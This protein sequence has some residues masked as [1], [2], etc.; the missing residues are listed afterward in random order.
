MRASDT[1]PGS[2]AEVRTSRHLTIR[3]SLPAPPQAGG[4]N[5]KRKLAP[6][7]PAELHPEA[8]QPGRLRLARRRLARR[9]G[10]PP[11]SPFPLPRPHHVGAGAVGAAGRR[12]HR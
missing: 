11:P 10:E 3:R 8:R 5:R 9:G 4:C 2:A 6:P 1:V 12:G 7:C